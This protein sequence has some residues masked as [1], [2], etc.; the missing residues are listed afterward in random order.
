MP[1][2]DVN[3]I[4]EQFE[5]TGSAASQVCKRCKIRIDS[6]KKVGKV[7]N[8]PEENQDVKC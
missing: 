4:G 1:E 8:H 2:K 6:D 3:M 5:I 7:W